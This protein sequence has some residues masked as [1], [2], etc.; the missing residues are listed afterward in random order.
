MSDVLWIASFDI[1]YRNLCFS[2]EEVSCDAL[3]C[4]QPIPK[5]KRYNVDGTPTKAQQ[6]VLERVYTNAKTIFFKNTDLTNKAMK[7][8]DPE[9]FHLLTDL[10]DKYVSYWDNCSYIVLE[11]QM[12][13]RG[14]Y[15]VSA[16]KLGQH[17]YSYFALRYGRFKQVIEFPAYH[18]T[19]VLG[20]PKVRKKTKKISYKAMDKPTRKKWAIDEAL[21]I[22]GARNDFETMSQLESARKKDDIAD[23]ILQ[24]VSAAYLIFVEK[25]Y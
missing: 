17:C 5:D 20:A 25:V 12:S 2:I 1:G 22:L 18:K 11:K 21:S 3:R 7:T 8:L 4:I 16:L 14:V 19:Q 9:V 13:F 15:N 23:C 10:L 6:N 24:S